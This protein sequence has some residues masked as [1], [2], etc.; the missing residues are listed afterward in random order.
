MATL[1]EVLKDVEGVGRDEQMRLA[2]FLERS[3]LT[4]AR[5]MEDIIHGSGGVVV[6]AS[7]AA[8]ELQGEL[9]IS[10]RKMLD[11]I[12][13]LMKESVGKSASETR[14]I[15]AKLKVVNETLEQSTSEE[16]KKIQEVMQPG[17]AAMEAQGSIG[18][19]FKDV[20][21]GRVAG[22]GDK[23]LRKVPLV[24]GIAADVLATSK[25]RKGLAAEQKMKIGSFAGDPVAE[26]L[27]RIEKNTRITAD[28]EKRAKKKKARGK[29]K[30]EKK[31]DLLE[32]DDLAEAGAG[33]AV[34]FITGGGGGGDSLLGD[35]VGGGIGATIAG[36]SG[37]AIGWLAGAVGLKALGGV[38]GGL[39]TGASLGGIAAAL[40]TAVLPIAIAGGFAYLLADS[41]TRQSEAAAARH[42]KHINLSATTR[43]RKTTVEGT[44]EQ[45]FSKGGKIYTES[46]AKS[47]A[48]AD[49]LSVE[50]A[51]FVAQTH[52]VNKQTGEVMFGTPTLN[53]VTEEERQASLRQ[54]TGER[55][56]G[57]EHPQSRMKSAMLF[58]MNNLAVA[59]RQM[60]SSI[61][62]AVYLHDLAK[63]GTPLQGN[64]D[65]HKAANNAARDAYIAG[66]KDLMNLLSGESPSINHL[67]LTEEFKESIR[68]LY[69]FK[70]GYRG[71][72][73]PRGLANQSFPG[74]PGAGLFEQEMKNPGAMTKWHRISTF[75]PTGFIPEWNTIRTGNKEGW[76]NKA[77]GFREGGFG[78]FGDGGK[79]AMF[80]GDELIIPMNKILSENSTILPDH[81]KA[82]LNMITGNAL[83]KNTPQLAG[84]GGS[85]II[86]PSNTIVNANTENNTFTG[87]SIRNNDSS[88]MEANRRTYS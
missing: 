14:D 61:K 37:R 40:G 35:I 68:E 59:E 56:L 32:D 10:G 83:V 38:V 44:D 9:T 53:K 84:M 52:A 79:L 64:W 28:A 31:E 45:A 41:I 86:A 27:E 88:L 6:G 36:M 29:S 24:G 22:F 77:E 58:L 34:A 15:L 55:I 62:D 20:I 78:R 17:L 66:Y 33:G 82:L 19:V 76:K 4:G 87:G 63:R 80:H 81:V 30:A 51:G 49:G 8:I 25:R 75:D 60:F 12:T 21:R 42:E 47:L 16:A 7:L 5:A 23:M 73:D 74:G 48:A 67:Q 13:E 46:E 11:E 85:I 65:V 54:T 26:S 2:T 3:K 50:D 18:N 69:G 71:R 72:H 70:T 43:R 57:T 1:Q 39:F